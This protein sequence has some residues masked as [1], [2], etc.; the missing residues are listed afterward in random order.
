MTGADPGMRKAIC[1]TNIYAEI[2]TLYT[3]ANY[4]FTLGCNNSNARGDYFDGFIEDFRM[5]L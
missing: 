4:K 5:Y 2:K 3:H 1:N